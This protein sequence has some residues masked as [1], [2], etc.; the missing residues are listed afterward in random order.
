LSS[1]VNKIKFEQLLADVRAD[2]NTLKK[3]CEI[4]ES[5]VSGKIPD[6]EIKNWI[7]DVF[8]DKAFEIDLKTSKI[9][10]ELGDS[11]NTFIGTL[12][13][14]VQDLAYQTDMRNVDSYMVTVK[15][16]FQTVAHN[17]EEKFSSSRYR[18]MG[19]NWSGL[20]KIKPIDYVISERKKYVTSREELTKAKEKI[21]SNPED[22]M[23]HLRTAIDLSI[24]E[25]FGFSKIHKMINFLE[26]AERLDFTLPSYSLIYT[27][28]NEGSKRLHEGKVHT[29]FEAREAIRT[30]TN[31]IDELELIQVTEEQ[32]QNFKKECKFVE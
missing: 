9:L 30:V 20:E 12:V 11:K 7:F 5:K 14:H 6:E 24:R 4:L 16:D 3:M 18:I 13:S 2:L 23:G 29:P 28:F 26:D 25:R 10:V 8:L 15:T 31:F 19:N 27:Y 1:N 17:I 22:V 32:T 21:E